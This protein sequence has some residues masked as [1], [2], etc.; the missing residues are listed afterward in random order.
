MNFLGHSRISMEIDIKTMYGNFTGDFYKGRLENLKLP[1]DVKNGLFLHR[2]IDSI[3]DTGNILTEKIDKK[4]SIF[5]GVISDIIIDHF[6]ALEWEK[7]FNEDLNDSIKMVYRELDKYRDI[8]TK[9]FTEVYNWISQN[10]ILYSY[11]NPENIKKTFA[12][13]SKRVRKGNILTEAY[14]ELIKKYD[15]FHRLGIE[16]FRRTADIACAEYAPFDN[17]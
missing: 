5:R 16:E 2:K 17:K 4:F 9:D 6:L 1:S 12:G 11:K 8:Y 3:S 14:D 13:I 7:L 15:L 10:N